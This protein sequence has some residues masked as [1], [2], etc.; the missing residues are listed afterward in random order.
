MRKFRVF[1]NQYTYKEYYLSSFKKLLEYGC[2][3][4]AMFIKK[5]VEKWT[6]YQEQPPTNA[7]ETAERFVTLIDD[8]SY[9]KTFYPKSNVTQWINGLAAKIYQSIYQNKKEKYSRLFDF[10]KYELPLLFKK[11]HKIFLF[12]LILFS[13]FVVIGVVSSIYN[14]QFI[15][16]VLGNEYVSMTESNISKG[17]PF[18]VYKDDN[19]F[20]M[21]VRIAFNN[22]RVAFITFMTG[23]TLGIYTVKVLWSNGLML[24]T[25]QYMFFTHDLGLQSIMVIW[26]HGTIE[27]I[28]I[29]IGGAAGLVLANGILF[30]K[31]FTRFES[32]KRGAKDAVKILICLVPFFII[33]AFFESYLTHLMSQTYDKQN[34]IGMPVWVSALILAG[35]LFLMVWY[36]V[37][38]PIKLHNRGFQLNKETASPKINDKDA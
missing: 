21:F 14:P 26:I 29:V 34:N 3:R 7:E 20:S 33:A 24:G 16:G 22:I 30:P 12:T 5:N 27:I 19:P 8:L 18:G 28:S 17:D 37:I 15:R 23:F 2:M 4:E 32:F 35:S 13:A 9:A 1:L 31:T 36:F 38:W 10:W 6:H 25:F 11:Y